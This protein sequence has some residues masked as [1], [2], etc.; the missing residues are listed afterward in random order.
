[1]WGERATRVAGAA[2]IL[3]FVLAVPAPAHNGDPSKVP[4]VD[5]I[6]PAV[7]GVKVRTVPGGFGKL[8]LTTTGSTTAEVLG[9]SGQPILRVGPR[10]VEGNAAAPEWYKDNE[11]LGI[12]KVPAAAKRGARARWVRVS[13]RRSWEW[14]D[15]RLHPAGGRVDRWSIPIV[16]DGRKAEVRGRIET[17]PGSLQV[18]LDS[19][20]L[21]PGV[22]VSAIDRPAPSLLLRNE[23]GKTVS[24][25]GPD[26]E[27]FARLGPG[28][29]EVN[30]HSALWVPTAQYGNRD[31]LSSVVDPGSRPTFVLFGRGRELIWPDSR[32]L[33]R[34]V[35]PTSRTP[36]A[37]GVRV[38]TW[39]VPAVIGGPGGHR[40]SIRGSTFLVPGPA[41]ESSPEKPAGSGPVSASSEND[42]G[43]SGGIWIAVAIAATI[44]G[45]GAAL[46]IRGR[47][48]P[49]AGE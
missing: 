40:V 35:V 48:R 5:S 34:S 21:A 29:D 28:G 10:G 1:M 37:G 33:P 15:H 7:E 30:V 46:V 18:R 8:A 23:G 9:G 19:K 11:P 4:V 44:V 49:P 14:F 47:R 41:G 3:S 2:A 12:A 13:V 6:S 32:L 27:V 20:T 45:G 39:S 42:D 24:V 16:V 31:L 22:S 26:G 17:A 25:L 36:A 43:S 38:A